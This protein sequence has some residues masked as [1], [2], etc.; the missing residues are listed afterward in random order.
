MR[1][2]IERFARGEFDEYLPK[3]EINKKPLFWEMEPEAVFQGSF[4]FRSE[5]GVRV[6]GYA[7]CTDGN[8][9]IENPQFFGKNI[10]IEFTYSS[11][12]AAN[13]DKKRGKLFLI[14]NAGEFVVPFD[15]KVRENIP[16]EGENFHGQD[17]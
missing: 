12:N 13:G 4:R 5:N 15:V 1:E 2:K 10:K 6:R 14:T 11:R 17:E 7:I 9:K 16:E 8:M 3:L